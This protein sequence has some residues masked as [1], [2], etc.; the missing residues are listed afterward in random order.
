MK[1]IS[2]SLVLVF[3]NLDILFP[4]DYEV[5]YYKP[6][7]ENM[8]IFETPEINGKII[9]KTNKNNLLK[10]IKNGS[11]VKI[12]NIQGFWIQVDNYFER[13]WCFSENLEKITYKI[14]ISDKTINYLIN[15][16]NSEKNN[17]Y[18]DFYLYNNEILW[19]VSPSQKYLFVTTKFAW[20][21]PDKQDEVNKKCWYIIYDLINNKIIYQDTG[22]IIFGT[23]KWLEDI[24]YLLYDSGSDVPRYYIFYDLKNIKPRF[25]I[26]DVNSQV[27]KNGEVDYKNSL[28]YTDDLRYFAVLYWVYFDQGIPEDKLKIGVKIYDS[29]IEKTYL[30][31]VYDKKKKLRNYVNEIKN[32]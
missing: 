25:F 15:N 3:L 1:S 30:F 7:I 28:Y 20:E 22:F 12:D 11:K 24:D 2:I 4:L 8:K 16:F 18:H 23:F 21:H 27:G 19:Q 29:V 9:S 13:G 10:Y 6:K 32:K 31:P 5:I 26:T 17:G 14:S